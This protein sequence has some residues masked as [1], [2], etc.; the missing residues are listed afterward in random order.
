MA[1]IVPIELARKVFPQFSFVRALAPSVQ[2]AAFFVQNSNGDNLCLKI[3]S[4]EYEKERL[5]RELQALQ[6]LSHPNIAKLREYVYTVKFGE[7]LHYIIEDY[8][9]GNDLSELIG[10]Q[11]KWEPRKA[12]AFFIELLQ[13]LA[14]LKSQNIVHR[15]LK[16]SNIRVLPSGSP[17]IIDFGLARHLNLTDLTTTDF[18]AAI[19]TPKYFAP[20]QFVGTK[21]DIDHRTDLYAV[22][23]LFYEVLLGRH[24]YYTNG[25]SAERFQELALGSTS[26]LMEPDFLALPRNVILLISRLLAKQ[27]VNRPGEAELAVKLLK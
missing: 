18:G 11:N 10:T 8:I 1:Y 16:P 25:I 20:E 21:R 15:D 3:I 27:R 19:G 17:V 5:E 24:P 22:G 2:K 12:I 23:L 13:G 9:E 14:A 6:S 4:P 26:F 7:V